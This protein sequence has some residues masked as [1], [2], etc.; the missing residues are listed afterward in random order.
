MS[1]SFSTHISAFHTIYHKMKNELY[2]F[3]YTSFTFL[4]GVF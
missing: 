2:S 3:A 4:W 1:S